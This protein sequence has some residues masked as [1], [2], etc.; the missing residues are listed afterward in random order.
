METKWTPGTWSVETDTCDCGGDYGCDHGEFP[1]ALKASE[2]RLASFDDAS[3]E[4]AHLLA[5]SP[6]L[7]AALQALLRLEGVRD[8]E[9]AELN[10]ARLAS[11]AAL[12]R[13]RGES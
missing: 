3:M 10:Q 13:A 4:D 8:D 9:D 6:D 7:Y 12:K 5:A 2:T 11:I 1:Y